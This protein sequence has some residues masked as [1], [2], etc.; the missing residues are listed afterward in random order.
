MTVP[1]L[2]VTRPVGPPDAPLLL[3]G[4]SLGTSG[5]LWDSAG[6]ALARTHRIV[7]W[8]LPG[9]GASAPASAP[10][11]MAELADAVADAID[12]LGAGPVGYV[13][14]SLSGC[15]G[16]EL[17]RRH[18]DRVSRAAIICSGAV[19][20]E[21]DAWRARAAQVRAQGTASL[22]IGAAQRW[23]APGSVAAHPE[24]TGRLLHALR[25]TDDEN[26][27]LCC[28]ALAGFDA[29]GRLGGIAAP[30]LAVWGAHDEV[31][32]EASARE[33][34]DGVRNGRAEGIPD[35]SHLAPVDDP[36]AVVALVDGFFGGRA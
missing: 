36:D 34:A 8:D 9:H 18:P 5:I 24:L 13:G 28:E 7:T 16:L 3:L 17:L 10:F 35:A 21:P 1:A 22:I 15:V 12:R 31:T 11:T 26:Y 33:I 2:T 32:P 20:G 4:P 29:R 23:F 6:P 27:A 14:V 25:D 19:I 30:V